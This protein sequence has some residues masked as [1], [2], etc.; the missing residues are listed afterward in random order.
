MANEVKISALPAAD[1]INGAELEPIVQGGVTKKS[2]KSANLPYI[3][4]SAQ[5]ASP[6]QITGLYGG[7]PVTVMSGAATT[8]NATY[9]LASVYNFYPNTNVALQ[10]NLPTLD[11]TKQQD[12]QPLTYINSGSSGS[13][14][15]AYR[16]NL[17]IG[18]TVGTGKRLVAT[19][20]GIGLSGYIEGSASSHNA[21]DFE[22]PS[23]KDV[24]NGYVGL[25]LLKIVF[26]NTLGTF[27]SYF[28]NA[29]TAS[30]TYNFQDRDAVKILD[31][32]D[33]SSITASLAVKQPLSG[34][35]VSKSST[36]FTLSLADGFKYLWSEG[37][38]ITLPSK[39]SL[40]TLYPGW[41]T[42]IRNTSPNTLALFNRQNPS[43][44]IIGSN[45][46]PPGR[47]AI[48]RL[49]IDSTNRTWDSMWIPIGRNII[50]ISG[51][52]TLSWEHFNG[53]I[54]ATAACVITVPY[55]VSNSSVD[56]T[57]FNCRVFCKTTGAVSIAAGSNGLGSNVTIDTNPSNALKL[58]GKGAAAEI[59]WL[60][61]NYFN[62]SGNII[63]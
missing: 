1:P 59:T 15:T 18:A 36:N 7:A 48:L 38:V 16:D 14:V 47:A 25:E 53:D 20:N 61:T 27:K 6:N 4:A 56:L 13:S 57:E 30:R 63:Q 40:P 5:L 35:D 33:L 32:T 23:N 19:T 2:P 43:D 31:D 9:P 45:Y 60:S 37:K 46:I 10:F 39:A 49:V 55:T 41:F 29:N 42:I 24:S 22:Q 50:E 26:K 54:I 17:Q 12:G 52:T 34:I 3:N 21:E 44:N 58:A 28:A 11:T 62:L 8:Y 51:N